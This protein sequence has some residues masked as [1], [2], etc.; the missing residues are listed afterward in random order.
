[1]KTYQ[2]TTTTAPTSFHIGPS[3]KSGTSN[4][5]TFSPLIHANKAPLN[6]PRLTAGWTMEL[7]I[8]RFSG[9]L[10]M[11]VPSFFLSKLP[12]G[13]KISC[14]KFLTIFLRPGVPGATASRA[15][16]SASTTGSCLDLRMFETVDFPVAMPPV[17][18]ITIS[19]TDMLEIQDNYRYFVQYQASLPHTNQ[20]NGDWQA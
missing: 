10:K 6:K 19:T 8:L 14:P 1:M 7:R 16:T 13:S 3:I 20:S 18:P 2:C 4:M 11:M 17:R 15:R 5:Q 9:S 12:S